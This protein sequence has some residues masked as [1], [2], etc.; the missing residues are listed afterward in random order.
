M[1]QH[2]VSS[3]QR[4]AA[5]RFLF[6]GG[7]RWRAL[8]VA[9][10][11]LVARSAALQARMDLPPGYGPSYAM[12]NVPPGSAAGNAR[13]Y[14]PQADRLLLGSP[15]S[16][17]CPPPLE[18]IYLRPV[19]VTLP[20]TPPVNTVHP[21]HPLL[22]RNRSRRDPPQRRRRARGGRAGRGHCSPSSKPTPTATAWPRWHARW[23]TRAR[24]RCSAWR[25]SSRP[26]TCARCCPMPP[27]RCSRPRCPTNARR[28]C[29]WDSCRGCRA[30]AE[31]EDYARHA[32]AQGRAPFGVEIK[33]DT[34][35]GRCRRAAAGFPGVARGGRTIARVAAGGRGDAP[36]FGR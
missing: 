9:G 35:M 21:S 31:A 2:N 29:R 30:V 3:C 23:R 26:N 6:Y 25:T 17:L 36:A 22:G 16:A 1:G 28:S 18:P 4:C 27:S 15:V 32:E 33:I 11:E 24:S 7:G 19:S 13:C 10:P 20:K 8:H 12:E 5:R 34:G 14:F